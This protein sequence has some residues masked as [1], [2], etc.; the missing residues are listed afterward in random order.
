MA[1]TI[2]FTKKFETLKSI[3]TESSFRLKYC[4]EQFYLGDKLSSSAVHPMVSFSNQVL[5]SID[6]KNITYGRYGIGLKKS[7]V[8]K[9]KLHP[10][11]YIDRN[12]HLAN[13]LV[14]LLR[15]RRKNAR[16]ELAPHVKLSIITIKC[17][18]KNIIGYNSY[19]KIN[20]FNFR[21]EKEWR[22]VPTKSDIGGSLISQTKK[23]YD[24]RP[25]YYNRKLNDFPLQFTAEDIE[26]I[27]VETEKQRS[28]IAENFGIAKSIIKLSKW[29]TDLKK[30]KGEK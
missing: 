15:A 4:R 19:F 17:F 10:V 20:D 12:S 5:K 30:V 16:I 23:L 2:H 1:S 14:D 21:V 3:L 6:K 7:W 8:E 29:S 25:D 18:T 27:F 11:L 28:I 13:A 22:Y 9:K 24:E 26:C